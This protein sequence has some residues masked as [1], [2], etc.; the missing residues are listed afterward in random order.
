MS[1]VIVTTVP[2]PCTT[3]PFCQLGDVN[4]SVNC[5]V[6]VWFG[7]VAKENWNLPPT[8]VEPKSVTVKP[9]SATIKTESDVDQYLAA[10]RQQLMQHVSAN[11]TVII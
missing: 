11:E 4:E 9:A 6:S 3:G 5:T 1:S 2:S 7:S 8:L 10:F